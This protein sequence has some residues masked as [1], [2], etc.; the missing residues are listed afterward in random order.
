[1]INKHTKTKSGKLFDGSFRSNLKTCLVDSKKKTLPLPKN[2]KI[3]NLTVAIRYEIDGKDIVN[4]TL[5]PDQIPKN[6]NGKWVTFDFSDVDIWVD[7]RYYIVVYSDGGDEK[8]YYR[9][10]YGENNPY[11][12]GYAKNSTDGGNSWDSLYDI[13]FCFKTYSSISGEEPDGK[14]ERWALLV[15]VDWGDKATD[16]CDNDCIGWKNVLVHH[17]WQSDHIIV[18]TNEQATKAN[19]LSWLNWIDAMENQDD[20]VA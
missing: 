7:T 9:W 2:S 10:Y 18:L 19:I 15:G 13:D 8:N 1:M 17:G 11:F 12:R 20:I 5:S 6:R 16:C 4:K 14:V 3:G